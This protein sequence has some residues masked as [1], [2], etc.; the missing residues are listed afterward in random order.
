[1]TSHKDN[2]E[3]ARQEN[4]EM[5]DIIVGMYAKMKM[6]INEI[7]RIRYLMKSQKKTT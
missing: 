1:M 7:T 2:I 3:A 4:M 5:E 6:T